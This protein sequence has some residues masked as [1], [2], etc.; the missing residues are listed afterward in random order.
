MEKDYRSEIM[1]T[2]LE[3]EP[4]QLSKLIFV[5]SLGNWM[6]FFFFF[7][8]LFVDMLDKHKYLDPKITSNILH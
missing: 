6:V 7:F 1:Q 3:G 5:R 2:R 8:C 4:K